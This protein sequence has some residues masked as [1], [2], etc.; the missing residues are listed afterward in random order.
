MSQ[1]FLDSISHPL[2]IPGGNPLD[3]S[4]YANAAFC[5]WH[6]SSTVGPAS[7][8]SIA[9]MSSSKTSL[10][11]R[12]NR[13]CKTDRWRFAI[14]EDANG[15]HLND[16]L[17]SRQGSTLLL[18]RHLNSRYFHQGTQFLDVPAPFVMESISMKALHFDDP[19]TRKLASR[20]A[21]ISTNVRVPT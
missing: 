4:P 11:P 16:R 12:K 18:R 5:K 21:R 10:N 17:A 15:Q 3:W 20:S 13:H 19:T 14:L 8:A 9:P 1:L 7:T 6:S 2:R